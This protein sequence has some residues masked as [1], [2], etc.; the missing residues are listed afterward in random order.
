MSISNHRKPWRAENG[1]A[2]WLLCQPS[3]KVISATH[4]LFRES[5]VV[6]KL[7]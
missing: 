3:P 7:R 1:N 6:S 5:S 2:W 4:Q